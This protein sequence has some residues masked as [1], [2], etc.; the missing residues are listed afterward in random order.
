MTETGKKYEVAIKNYIKY[1]NQCEL[2]KSF[3]EFI[4]EQQKDISGSVSYDFDDMLL[5][6]TIEISLK[7]NY[8]QQ[9]M[10]GDYLAVIKS[11]NTDKMINALMNQKPKF[12][13]CIKEN[14][15]PICYM[16]QNIF[17][18]YIHGEEIP[19]DVQEEYIIPYSPAHIIEIGQTKNKELIREELALTSEKTGDMEILFN[20][21]DFVIYREHPETCY[22]RT[23]DGT[24]DVIL[25]KDN[26]VLDDM[27]EDVQFDGYRI[28][29]LRNI[30]NSQIPEHFLINHRELVDEILRKMNV[31]YNLE[32]I[33]AHGNCNDYNVI[34]GFIHNLYRVMDICGFKKDNKEH[35]LRSSR[36]DIE[37]LFYGSVSSI[38]LT[39]DKKLRTR[40]RNIYEVL[41]KNIKCPEI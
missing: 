16:D 2:N 27:I 22:N 33:E 21:N 40:A 10:Q 30:Y 41:G 25:A 38:F 31:P 18:L 6:H 11:I 17:T 5:L 14:K 23:Y 7:R 37:H 15:A 32:Y 1:G 8:T 9:Q 28:D 13:G 26:K 20:K 39:N 19:Y 36:I 24:G 29:K 34:N 3:Y 35:K 12:R 4:E